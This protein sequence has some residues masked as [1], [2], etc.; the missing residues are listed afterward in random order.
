MPFSSA[1]SEVV[2]AQISEF[3]G[4]VKPRVQPSSPGFPEDQ[5]RG[6]LQKL[7]ETVCE[8]GLGLD[9]VVHGEVRMVD[10]EAR[11]DFRVDVAGAPVGFIELKAPGRGADPERFS[12]KRD[13]GQWEKLRNLPSVLYCDGQEYALFRSGTR[14]G[15]IGRTNLTLARGGAKLA[16]ADERIAAILYDFL[17][18]EPTPPRTLSELVSAVAGLCRFLRNEVVEQLGKEAADPDR[19]NYFTTLAASWR[20]LLFPDESDASFADQ[21]AQTVAFGMLLARAEGIA[22]DGQDIHAISKRLGKKHSLM[23]QALALLA[24][25][26]VLELGL[27]SSVDTML[28]VIGAV[29]WSRLDDGSGDAYLHLYERFL[30]LY[31]PKLRQESGSYYTPAPIV[32]GMVSLVDQILVERHRRPLGVASE[33]V[34]LLDPAMGTG[35]FLLHVLDR[36][37]ANIA[38]IESPTSVGPR[39]RD[40]AQHRLH[41]FEKQTGPYAVAELRLQQALHAHGA[42]VPEAGLLTDVTDTLDDTGA[43]ARQLGIPPQLLAIAQSRRRAGAVKNDKPIMV[44]LGNPPYNEKARRLARGVDPAKNTRRSGEQSLLDA[45]RIPGRLGYKLA[46]LYVYFWRWTTWKVFDAHVEQPEGIVALIT[47]SAYCVGDAFAGMREYLRRTADEGW[48]IDL[49]PEGHFPDVPTR[50]FPEVKQQISVGIFTRYGAPRADEPA[51][52]HRLAIA[53]RRAEKLERLAALRLDDPAWQQCA[54]GWT[55]PFGPQT[56]NLWQAL[57]ELGELMPWGSA[58]VKANRPWPIDPSRETLRRRW[59]AL[60][61]APVDERNSLLKVTRDRHVETHTDQPPGWQRQPKILRD[62][63]GSCP[64]P[65]RIA[66]RPFDRQWIIPDKRVIDFPRTSL[67]SVFAPRQLFVIEQHSQPLTGGP[68]L[69]FS[70]LVPDTHAFNGRG[71]RT[72]PLY[73]DAAASSPNLAPGLLSHLARALG[74]DITPEDFIAYIAAIVAHPGYISAFSD[75]LSTPGG[76]RIPITN[77]PDLWTEAVHLGRKVIRL[78]VN[79]DSFTNSR[80]S[81]PASAADAPA[82]HV[83]DGMKPV[84]TVAIPDSRD[85]MPERITHDAVARSLHVGAGVIGNIDPAVWSYQVS[86]WPVVKKWFAYRAKTPAGR[87]A[88]D[89]D[90]IVA[91]RWEPAWTTELLNLLTALTELTTLEAEQAA[92]TERILS[93]ELIS[94]GVLESAGVLPVPAGFT[95]APRIE[96]DVLFEVGEDVA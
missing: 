64:D 71:G 91:T 65:I 68:A 50:P 96:T 30:K 37:A 15:S 40:L 55:D 1:F 89:L 82:A 23:G 85:G 13:R 90:H 9:A 2:K 32:A 75:E 58:G 56:S 36:A 7:M 74:A 44:V 34:V 93:S 35:T 6:P 79:D 73:R 39:L 87:S 8:L 77:D 61:H 69:L 28:R 26:A 46:S 16:P 49:S 63:A 31:D 3:G 22:F 18:W 4:R 83:P 54:S 21:Y 45:F 41:G 52:V 70:K 47:P 25:D 60:V 27:A 62:E 51:V 19:L 53:G 86:G 67:W 80:E 72:L 59:N 11:P 48:I 17:T 33:S 43:N 95:K 76:V 38:G 94:R 81:H 84:Y 92:L 42:E 24:D 29:D 20:S 88:T 14:V 57:P 66:Y 5:L 78:H 10:L 12:E